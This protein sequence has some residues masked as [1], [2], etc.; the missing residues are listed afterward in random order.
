MTGVLGV[1]LGGSYARGAAREDSD[2][3]GGVYYSE[4]SSL[5]VDAIRE[6]ATQFPGSSSPVVT[7]LLEWGPW[8][9]EG[10]GSPSK[11]SGSIF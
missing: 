7:Q 11:D 8:V 2:L 9:N 5:D 10:H 1:A 3:D 4:A 6:V